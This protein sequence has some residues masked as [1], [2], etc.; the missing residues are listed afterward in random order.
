MIAIN[1]TYYAVPDSRGAFFRGI[2]L[3]SGNDPEVTSRFNTFSNS[4][5]NEI[6]TIQ[7]YEVLAHDHLITTYGLTPE[8]VGEGG[9]TVSVIT[10]AAT[11]GTAY[12]GGIE[13]RPKN[14]YVNY[15]IKY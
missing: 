1:K 13:N 6:G 9:T 10:S 4:Y 3:G 15:V 2:D 11:S 14:M 7:L 5:G 12:Y 8:F